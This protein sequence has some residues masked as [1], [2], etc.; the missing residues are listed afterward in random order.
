MINDDELRRVISDGLRNL[1]ELLTKLPG[2]R[3][4]RDLRDKIGSLRQ[5]LLDQREPRF[6][7]VGRRG[8]GKSSLVNAILSEQVAT[9]GHETSATGRGQWYTYSTDRGSIKILDTR[10]LQ[11]GSRP[12]AADDASTPR[13][14]ILRELQAT[15]PD[16]VLFLVKAKE[17]D[18]AIDT[19]LSE[20]EGILKAI[21]SENDAIIPVLGVITNCDELE[22]KNVRL[23]Q[24]KDQ[25][26]RDLDEKL[27]RVRKVEQHLRDKFRERPLLKDRLIC[28][29]GVSSYQSWR[30]DGSRRD[31]ERWRI[32]ELVEKLVRELPTEARVELVRISRIKKLQKMLAGTITQLVAS[33]CAAVALSPLPVAD[34]IPLTSLQVGLVAGIA[35]ISG[36][37][38]TMKSAA[39][40]L[41]AVGANVGI[42]FAVRELARAVVKLLPIAGEAVSSAIAYATTLA[43]GKAAAAYFIDEVGEEEAK[44]IF[45]TTRND[46]EKKQEASDQPPT[47]PEAAQDGGSDF[48]APPLSP[49]NSD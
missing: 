26:P 38:L 29:L 8:S 4:T 21:Q 20:V 10:G 6:A 5:L 3:L 1:D 30:T 32:E 48:S 47:A 18:A 49:P 13:E 12:D 25:D 24:A 42:G 23:H 7:L 36:R 37:T 46:E 41:T 16:A 44:K 11:E 14:S 40:F 22:P 27:G 34:I 28:T 15:C 39:E 2:E 31:D 17:V 33:L 45:S 9:V 35:Y 43:I 19:D